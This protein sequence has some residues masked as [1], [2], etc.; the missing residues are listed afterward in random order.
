MESEGNSVLVFD[1]I[2]KRYGDVIALAPDAGS[3]KWDAHPATSSDRLR[4]GHARPFRPATRSGKAVRQSTS[5]NGME[6][7]VMRSSRRVA[8]IRLTMAMA[9]TALLPTACGGDDAAEIVGVTG[10]TNCVD[11]K[12][13]VDTGDGSGFRDAVYEC[14]MDLSDERLDSAGETINSCDI[15]EDGETTLAEC[16]GTTVLTNEGGTWE[17]TFSGT[18]TWSTTNPEHV[19]DMDFVF[20][21]T[22][23]YDGLQFVATM[24]GTDYPWNV[25]GQIEPID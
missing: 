14:T 17:G 21:G 24:E 12:N 7:M 22:G 16:R 25:A 18:S 5:D 13:G 20:V 3:I 2:S 8:L 11:V 19:H 6:A 4:F 1:N 15:T 23:D 10:T 9:A